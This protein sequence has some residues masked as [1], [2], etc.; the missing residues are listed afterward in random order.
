MSSQENQSGV[1]IFGQPRVIAFNYVLK[2]SKGELLDA[3]EPN[4]PM[5]FLEGKM[6]IIPK[7]EEVLSKMSEGEKKKV[8]L[9]AVDAYGEFNEKM[10]M[11]VE[12]KELAHLN[13][14]L[15]SHVQLDLGEQTRVVRVA[16]MTDTHVT[17]D[18]N[19]PLAGVDLV[20][21]IEVALVR[22]AT[23]DEV[24]HGHAHGL[25]GHAHHH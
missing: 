5:P 21:D 8:E 14:E 23:A 12:R 19:H 11:D 18:G 25:H 10:I 20:F 7:L 1:H 22:A 16:K 3:S 9:K 13:V 2:N 6:Q 15:G 24:K 17:L 4:Q